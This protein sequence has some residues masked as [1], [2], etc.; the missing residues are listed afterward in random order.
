VRAEISRKFALVARKRLNNR[1]G[2]VFYVNAF[3]SLFFAMCSKQVAPS[4]GLSNRYHWWSEQ[5]LVSIV[6]WYH[7]F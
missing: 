3:P 7:D 1:D 6:L 4:Y 2:N 5:V